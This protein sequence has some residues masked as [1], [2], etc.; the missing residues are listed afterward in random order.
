MYFVA[1]IPS[2]TSILLANPLA[3]SYIGGPLFAIYLEHPVPVPSAD[4]QGKGNL[5]PLVQYGTLV[6]VKVPALGVHSR[7]GRKRAAGI[8]VR[9]CR[10]PLQRVP[11]PHLNRPVADLQL[12][13]VVA[14]RVSFRV[15]PLGE[16]VADPVVAVLAP[17]G[18]VDLHPR[19]R[20]AVRWQ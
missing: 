20:Y 17:G 9:Y 3:A 11:G 13:H 10:V 14:E 19:L 15:L 16:R 6:A 8:T 2:G 4:E 5:P 12:F 18:Q 7:V 1:R